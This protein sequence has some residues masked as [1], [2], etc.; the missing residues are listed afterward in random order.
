MEDPNNFIKSL[1]EYSLQFPAVLRVLTFPFLAQ[2]A[3]KCNCGDVV[4]FLN[5]LGSDKFVLYFFE[6]FR[7]GHK[8][9]SLGQIL[10]RV[11]ALIVSGLR[12]NGCFYQRML[13]FTIDKRAQ[14]IPLHSR[15]RTHLSNYLQ[16][17]PTSQR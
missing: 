8:Y 16:E 4:T 10:R 12:N 6:H 11:V 3:A 17:K 13:H 15:R 5:L 1:R 2:R 14:K 9:N 7:V